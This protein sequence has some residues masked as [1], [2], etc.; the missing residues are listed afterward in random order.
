[1]LKTCMIVSTLPVFFYFL[2][3]SHVGLIG[4]G[5]R[6]WD[7]YGDVTEAACDWLGLKD[8]FCYWHTV[9]LRYQ[10]TSQPLLL[11]TYGIVFFDSTR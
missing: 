9:E 10:A 5:R 6:G 7:S 1:M 4:G 11:Y 8:S 2:C 3:V